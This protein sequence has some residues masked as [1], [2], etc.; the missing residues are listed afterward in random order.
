MTAKILSIQVGMPKEMTYAG[1]S[2]GEER[3]WRSGIFKSKIEGPATLSDT[4]LIGDGQ[5]NLAVHGG[6]DRAMLIFGQRNYPHW[7]AHLGRF[8]EPG[9]FGENLTVDSLL[10]DDVCLG[11]IWETDRVQL[12]VSQPRLPCSNLGRRLEAPEIVGKIMDA[13]CGGWYVRAISHGQIEAGETLRLTAR[14]HPHWTIR[15]AFDVYVFN[16][17]DKEAV[18][19]LGAIPEI[20]QLWKDG[21]ARLLG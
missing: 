4:G 3:T 17:S 7:E 13:K 21:I 15:R 14:P 19:E 5:E 18:A 20:S 1:R 8:L 12:Q 9:S 10:E 6:P 16:R 2:D 11:D